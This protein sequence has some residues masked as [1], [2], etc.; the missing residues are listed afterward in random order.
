MRFKLLV[1]L[2]NLFCIGLVFSAPADEQTNSAASVTHIQAGQALE[3]VKQGGVIVLDL[4][5]PKEFAGGHIVG[6]TNVDCTADGFEKRL[7]SLERGKTYLIHCASGRRSTNALPVFEKL[8]FKRITH[9]DGGLKG[10]E[11][12]KQPVVKD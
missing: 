8:G 6:A 3:L 5:T 7:E 9:L 4:R 12:A 2:L 11:A 1:G 10:W